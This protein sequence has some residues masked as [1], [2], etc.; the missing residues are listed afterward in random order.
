MIGTILA[1]AMVLLGPGATRAGAV[2]DDPDIDSSADYVY[3]VDLDRGLV[4]VRVELT[5]TADKPDVTTADR[6]FQYFYQGYNLLVPAEAEDLRVVDSNGTELRFERTRAD[7]ADSDIV[8][9]DF[10]RNIFFG[11]SAR[12]TVRF[13]LPAGSAGSDNIARI[14]PAYASFV[15]WT[16][17]IIEQATVTVLLPAGFEDRS[18]G[19]QPFD[20]EIDAGQQR[21]VAADVDPETY[22]AVVSVAN[23]DALEQDVVSL[24]DGLLDPSLTID[25]ESSV[26]VRSW[27]GDEQWR[28]HVID[29]VEKGLPQLVELVGQPWPIAGELTITES[30]SP[31]LYGY[32]GWYDPQTNVIEVGDERDEHVLYHE[33][34]HVWFN[35]DLFVERW[36]TEGLADFY[37]AETVAAIGGSRP[38]PRPTSPTDPDAIPLSQFDRPESPEEELWGYS[39]SW[40]LMEEVVAEIGVDGLAAVVEA[41]EERHQPYPGDGAPETVATV[42]DWRRFL[43]LIENQQQVVEGPVTDLIEAWV[44]DG[45]GRPS[46]G[47]L[48]DRLAARRRYFT[49]ADIGDSWAPPS[50]V[51]EAMMQWRFPNAQELMEG[52]ESVLAV[53]DAI[54]EVIAPTG[55]ELPDRLESH[56]EEIDGDGALGE[57]RTELAAADAAGAEVR[58]AHDLAAAERS[59]LQRIGLIGADVEAE[60]VEAVAAFSAGELAAATRE[61]DEVDDIINGAGRNGLYR[62][63]VLLALLL[64]IAAVAW[65][66]LLRPRRGRRRLV[67]H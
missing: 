21:L 58:Q 66:V 49:L 63:A 10:Q 24:T 41:A 51:R 5:V 34:S 28:R 38:A 54:V 9:I 35:R 30:F 7:D 22:Y 50:G 3:A 60:R 44:L 26:R 1:A 37:A 15:A 55:A 48:E 13:T 31:Y 39:A 43:D 52:S 18:T 2:I 64:L 33:L 11:Q 8:A 65:F 42:A 4:E 29:G 46:E 12:L 56:Y 36:I 61:A 27:P 17:P 45:G 47:S 23:D 40:A 59:L 25:G 53:R 67:A 19:P 16:S 20:I 6:V 32:A 57:L 62:V 14:N